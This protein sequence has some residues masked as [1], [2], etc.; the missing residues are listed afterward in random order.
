M[1]WRCLKEIDCDY[2]VILWQHINLK[3][4][5]IWNLQ[6]GGISGIGLCF[7]K[8]KINWKLWIICEQRNWYIFFCGMGRA[9]RNGYIEK[10]TLYTH[11]NS[12][13]NI[14]KIWLLMLY[15]YCV[16]FFLSCRKQNSIY[17]N[18]LKKDV[19]YARYKLINPYG[20]ITAA[21]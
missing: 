17:N 16:Y 4:S 15:Y 8:F 18:G 12:R 21:A 3:R 6:K 20:S 19:T 13:N 5:S 1:L 11:L 7:A 10:D 2:A 9:V 14:Y